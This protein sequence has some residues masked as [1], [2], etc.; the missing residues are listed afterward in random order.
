M[1]IPVISCEFHVR[2]DVPEVIITFIPSTNKRY[3]LIGC[4]LGL[5][6]NEIACCSDGR[7]QTHEILDRCHYYTVSS[8][9]CL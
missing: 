7:N 8:S 1:N 4:L 2:F 3:C 5:K 6:A 9:G